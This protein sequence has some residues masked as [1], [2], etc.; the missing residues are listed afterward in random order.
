[1]SAAP[2]RQQAN[3]GVSAACS[4]NIENGGVALRRKADSASGKSL[5][6]RRDNEIGIEL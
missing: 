4:L 3:G 2:T 5:G 6:W 1:M